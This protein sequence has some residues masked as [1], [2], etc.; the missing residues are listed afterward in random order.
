MEACTTGFYWPF[1]FICFSDCVLEA[2]ARPIGVEPFV[3][4]NFV[5]HY[6]AFQAGDTFKVVVFKLLFKHCVFL[7]GDFTGFDGVGDF[8]KVEDNQFG[9]GFVS[10]FTRFDQIVSGDVGKR[11]GQN[12]QKLFF[13]FGQTVG[14]LAAQNI[15]LEIVITH[16]AT[17]RPSF[18]ASVIQA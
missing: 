7:L 5:G 13:V 12:E 10:Q 1:V 17:S 4:N 8:A 11:V 18:M 6:A 16:A 15:G 2:P 9:V 3:G 14:H